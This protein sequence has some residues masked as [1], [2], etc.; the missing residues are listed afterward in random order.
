MSRR[1]AGIVGVNLRRIRT[2]AGLT[3]REVAERAGLHPVTVANLETGGRK[4][5]DD[6]TVDALARALGV[7]KRDLVEPAMENA[8]VEPL[9]QEFLGS[10]WS[11]TLRPEIT[12]DEIEWLRGLPGIFW[13]G[14][15]PTPESLHHL[16]LAHRARAA[17]REKK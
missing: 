5:A 2:A 3:Q 14:M 7:R 12:Q 4:S 11:Q 13:I 6:A 9:L 8:A 16:I 1:K 15:P 10:P 17:A